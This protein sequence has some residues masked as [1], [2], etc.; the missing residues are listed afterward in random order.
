MQIGPKSE[1]RSKRC[2]ANS[3]VAFRKSEFIASVVPL[4]FK[5]ETIDG[6]AAEEMLQ[7]IGELELA[8]AAGLDGFDRIEDLRGQDVAPDDREVGRGFGRLGFFHHVAN[9]E[10][11]VARAVMLTGSASTAP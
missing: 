8:A 1:P 11:A 9:A 5:L 4:A 6:P 3:T 10:Q 2:S 7:R